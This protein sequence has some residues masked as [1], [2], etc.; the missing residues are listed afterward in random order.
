VRKDK[1][2]KAA[3]CDLFS[4]GNMVRDPGWRKEKESL[5]VV[6]VG[7]FSAFDSGESIGGAYFLVFSVCFAGLGLAAVGT[8]RV[9]LEE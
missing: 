6:E 3:L 7:A 8:S 5:R 4:A 9:L 1:K 2:W